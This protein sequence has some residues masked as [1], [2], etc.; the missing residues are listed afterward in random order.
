MGAFFVVVIVMIIV[1]L[2]PEALKRKVMSEVVL[3]C[4]IL[5]PFFLLTARETEENKEKVKV[6]SGGY[7]VAACGLGAYLRSIGPGVCGGWQHSIKKSTE[8]EAVK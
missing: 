5:M 7:S 4:V 1:L 6:E 8:K 2:R 3:W